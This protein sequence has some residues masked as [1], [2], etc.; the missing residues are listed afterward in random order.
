MGKWCY[1]IRYKWSYNPTRVVVSKM[2]YVHPYLGKWS[3]L[4]STCFKWVAQ[5]PTRKILA[6]RW[7][8]KGDYCYCW[9]MYL[10][11]CMC[12]FTTTM[13]ITVL[14][15]DSAMGLWD[16]SDSSFICGWWLTFSNYLSHENLRMA[17]MVKVLCENVQV[18]QACVVCNWLS[19]REFS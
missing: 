11:L 17:W 16:T 4:T 10:Q 9:L 12:L 5:P 2:F 18:K 7:C 1:F 13:Q 15:S 3:N 8:V 14:P 6:M 19:T